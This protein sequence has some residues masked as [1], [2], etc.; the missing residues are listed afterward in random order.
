M[1]CSAQ[2]MP[3][4]IHHM[5]TLTL[6]SDNGEQ[7]GMIVTM[8]AKLSTFAILNFFIQGI[9]DYWH[10]PWGHLSSNTSSVFGR[11][12]W[13]SHISHSLCP[14]AWL[15]ILFVAPIWAAFFQNLLLHHPH[16]TFLA[17]NL[18]SLTVFHQV[19]SMFFDFHC[20]HPYPTNATVHPT[21][22]EN[23]HFW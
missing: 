16:L 21:I 2:T 15:H 1:Q 3:I 18:S 17:Y 12:P 20:S 23:T 8:P 22:M 11:V 5:Q 6:C 10:T 4:S 14:L 13:P 19:C 7:L 9:N